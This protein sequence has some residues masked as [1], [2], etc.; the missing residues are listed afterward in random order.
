MNQ[1]YSNED[2]E[3]ILKLAVQQQ[4]S[5]AGPVSRDS[6]LQTASELGLTPEQVQAAEHLL[7]QKKQEFS[8][9]QDEKAARAEYARNRR[10]HVRNQLSSWLGTSALTFGI[11]AMTSWGSWWCQWVIIPWGLSIMGMVFRTLVHS[12]DED[13][14]GFEE[15]LEEQEDVFKQWNDLAAKKPAS[16]DNIRAMLARGDSLGASRALEDELK[17]DAHD[18]RML[19]NRL[20]Q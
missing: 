18:R 5:G 16:A 4:V 14:E 1:N 7:R 12:P 10:S 11:N 17:L 8:R 3:E 9:Y 19:I 15:W 2:A 20:S 13:H 6:L